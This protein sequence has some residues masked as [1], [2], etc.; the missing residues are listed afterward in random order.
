MF[1]QLTD[2]V[3]QALSEKVDAATKSVKVSYSNGDTYEGQVYDLEQNTRHGYGIYSYADGQ[4]RYEGE[5]VDDEKHG[6]GSVFGM[7]RGSALGVPLELNI[8]VGLHRPDS[9]GIV[10]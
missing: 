9:S 3:V 2:R 10:P 8:G 7:R 6:R 1:G 5:F 4:G